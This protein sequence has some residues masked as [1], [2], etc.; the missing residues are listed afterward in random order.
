VV[1]RLL[2]HE[3]LTFREPLVRPEEDEASDRTLRGKSS[4]LKML[5]RLLLPSLPGL[6]SVLCILYE[7]ALPLHLPLGTK[8]GLDIVPSEEDRMVGR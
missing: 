2:G 7:E 3:G 5:D 6:T 1:I 8:E 4:P